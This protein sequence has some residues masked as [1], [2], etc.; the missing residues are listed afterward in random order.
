MGGADLSLAVSIWRKRERSRATRQKR[1]GEKRTRIESLGGSKRTVK[2]ENRIA[3]E[4]SEREKERA[5][6]RLFVNFATVV[7]NC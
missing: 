1:S 7:I 4:R 5:N 2:N 3:L 6:Y